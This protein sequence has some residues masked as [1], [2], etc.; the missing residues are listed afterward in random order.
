MAALARLWLS[1]AVAVSFRP[2]TR[3]SAASCLRVRS[4]RAGVISS[5]RVAPALASIRAPLYS[6]RKCLRF[7]GFEAGSMAMLIQTL[8]FY[9]RLITVPGR[10]ETT[11]E[12]ES[13]SPRSFIKKEKRYS[14]R[15]ADAIYDIKFNYNN[16]I[17][18]TTLLPHYPITPLPHYPL[19]EIG[20]F[21]SRVRIG[22]C[23]KP[24]KDP[25]KPPL[26][27]GQNHSQTPLRLSNPRK[28]GVKQP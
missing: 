10:S 17:G 13:N 24:R 20:Q 5:S 19:A 14:S 6:P 4:I 8:S 2:V 16:L 28:Q 12:T 23:A 11:A 27:D 26:R 9:L 18:S 21:L 7:R 22:T 1:H 3:G 15:F 25:P